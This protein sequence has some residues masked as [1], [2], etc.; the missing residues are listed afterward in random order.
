MEFMDK[1]YDKLRPAVEKQ[2]VL[3]AHAELFSAFSSRDTLILTLKL[4]RSY[5]AENVRLELWADDTMSR[6]SLVYDL[7]RHDDEYDCFDFTLVLK[8]LCSGNDSGLFYYHFSF[9]CAEGHLY[10]SRNFDD[11]LPE[12]ISDSSRVSSY[13][14]TVFSADFKTPEG[15]KGKTM[16][17]I[18]VD[19]FARGEKAVPIRADAVM[20][21]DWYNGIPEYPERPGGFVKN[22]MFFGG[23]L[24]GVIEKL[25][26]LKELGVELLYLNPIFEAYSN[27]KYDTGDYMRVDEMF[28]GDEAFDALVRAAN[29]CGIGIILDGVFNHTGSDSMYFNKSGRYDTLGAYNSRDSK[30]ADWYMFKSFPDDYEAWWGIEILPKLNGKNESLREFICGEDGVIRHYLKR[31]AYGWRLDVADELDED[32]LEGIR[33]A[34]K[35][36]GDAPIIGEVWEDASNKVA[37]DRRRKYFR[38]H[39][40]DS[41]MN[42]PLRQAIIDFLLHGDAEKLGRTTTELYMHYPKQVSDCLMNFLGTHDT[43]RILTVLSGED[44]GALGNAELA[45]YRLSIEKRQSAKKL[46]KLAYLIIATVPGVPCIYYGD[47]VGVEGGHDPFNRMPFPWGREDTELLSAYK[48]IGRLRASE[49]LFARGYFKVI[50]CRDSV[51]VFE[52]FDDSRKL[53]VAVNMSSRDYELTVGG[54]SLLHDLSSSCFT[55]PPRSAELIIS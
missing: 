40:L 36:E 22:D 35:A 42:Y 31:G 29:D 4:P 13:Q 6:S 28:G 15:F 51:F 16:Y 5:A 53:T 33:E 30:Y 44:I 50:N 19:R 23:T 12:A 1:N 14:L 39:E 3:E 32:L 7:A 46:L 24:W 34:A 9:D 41:V 37:Y 38:G 52:R 49:P 47:E 55:V 54:T 45:G 18:F 26:Y 11:L 2:S 43:E 21:N 48:H 25:S 8:E 20:N 17:Q 27:H 10:V